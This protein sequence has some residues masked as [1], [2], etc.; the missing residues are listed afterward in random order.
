MNLLKNKKFL[1]ISGIVLGVI[2]IAAVVLIIIN[3][4]AKEEEPQPEPV[5]VSYR[6]KGTLRTDIKFEIVDQNGKVWLVNAD[7]EGVFISSVKDRGR[8]LEFALT[9]GGAT[10]LDE[11]LKNEGTVLSVRVDDKLVVSPVLKDE[12]TES[13]AIFDGEQAKEM[14][15]WRMVANQIF[16]NSADAPAS[17]NEAPS[18]TEEIT[19]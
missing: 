15:C 6:A 9:E 1:L 8:Y 4:F 12:I 14:E 18:S 3:P 13:S 2:I 10:K 16:D 5:K 11:A 19:E 7:V 17:S